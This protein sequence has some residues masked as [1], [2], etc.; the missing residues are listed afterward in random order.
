MRPRGSILL[1]VA[2]AAL[3]VTV[4]PSE[5][6]LSAHTFSV[7]AFDAEA[8]EFGVAVATF[9]MAVGRLCPFARAEVGAVATQANVNSG[10]GPRGLE[11]L[12]KGKTAHEA[13]EELLKDDR[14]REQRQLAIIDRSGNIA[15]H[16]GRECIKYAGHIIGPY[17]SVQ[18]NMLK[19]RDTLEA[20]DRVMRQV[21]DESGNRLPL[22][23]RLIR[24]LE[25]GQKAGGDFRGHRSAAVLV[26]RKDANG[27]KR[28]DRYVDF[29]VDDHDEPVQE[30][31]R[32]LN[33]NFTWKPRRYTFECGAGKAEITP[34]LERDGK[35]IPVF[36]AGFGTGRT[37]RDVHDPLWARAVA[38]RLGAQKAI[39]IE[40]DLVGLLNHR[41]QPMK[42]K[43]EEATQVPAA[44]I[45]IACTHNH[46]G[47]DTI[48]LWGPLPG[49]SGVNR[50]YME[51]L[52]AQ[53]VE[54]ARQAWNRLQP[55]TAVFAS[56]EI[57]GVTKDVRAPE[58]LNER[59]AAA[60]FQSDE[61]PV[62]VL[63]NWASHPEGIG[64]RNRSI[65]SDY[66]HYL[67]EKLEA[68]YRGAVAIHISGDLGGMQTPRVENHSFQELQRVGETIA[69]A[70]LEALKKS[71]PV[72]IERMNVARSEIEL[73]LDNPAFKKGLEAKIFGDALEAVR[74]EGDTVYLK[75][76]LTAI[77]L[78]DAVFATVPGEMFP[79]LGKHVY[80]A[81]EARYKFL[82]GLGNDELGYILP[83]E[84]W[85]KDGYEESMSLGPE[86]GPT[87]LKALQDLLKGF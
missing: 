43:I 78:Q 19:N 11:L 60:L 9:P 48:G 86:T 41:I 17:Y 55:A 27:W 29:R 1:G 63:V 32:I 68:A 26:T 61:G 42:K 76:E 16:T 28:W 83:K 62:C 25:A 23:V 20:M 69:T 53:V 6:E 84:D 3:L 50:N 75:S 44:N 14:L 2:V 24:A 64:S 46:S 13:L 85:R 79:E 58:V 37:A 36:M 51:F 45:I 77:R 39:L 8:R 74:R 66:P 22:A 4:R 81:M 18:G 33:K 73:R 10:Y 49:V 82:V 71:E 5:F 52:Q 57:P 67:R 31:A 12:E 38:F 35:K 87:V 65:T 15:V 47:P 80:T 54:A 7:V 21:I 56:C 40:C 30:L 72:R 34:A 59:A 70:V